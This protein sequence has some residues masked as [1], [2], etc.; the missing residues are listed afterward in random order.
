MRAYVRL[1]ARSGVVELMDV[2]VPE[3]ADHEVLVEIRA[4]GVGVHDRYFIPS[5]AAFPYPI[6]TE[7]SGV[8]VDMG[9]K[10]AEFEVGDAVVLTSL[11]SPKGGPWAQFAVVPERSLI[12]LPEKL[13][14]VEG[15]AIPIAGDAAL[16]SMKA[17]SLKRGD[18]LFIAG[19]SGAIGTLVIQLAVVRGI[20]VAGSASSRNHEY[21]RTLGADKAVDYSDPHTWSDES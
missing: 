15:A 4:F 17:L 18:S 7:A 13:S 2:S 20:R 8:I 16:E 10:V 11:L 6:G 5:N 21:M 3:I 14:F 12:R 1:G 9:S 19:A